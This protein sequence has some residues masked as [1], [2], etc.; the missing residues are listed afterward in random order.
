MLF[1]YASLRHRVYGVSLLI[2]VDQLPSAARVPAAPGEAAQVPSLLSPVVAPKN[3]PPQ[4][5]V[6]AGVGD[7]LAGDPD[8]V[9]VH[10]SRAVVTPAGARRVADLRLVAG[11]AV[12]LG[13]ALS[14]GDDVP[15]ADAD[16][17]I[18][19]RV[20]GARVEAVAGGGE[21]HHAAP[22]RR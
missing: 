17:R 12:V 8:R 11:E 9:A 19:R 5:G 14:A 13:G 6:V 18:D 4:V 22:A 7:V 20:G 16:D 21:R 10:G 3:R 1:L 15:R 2:R